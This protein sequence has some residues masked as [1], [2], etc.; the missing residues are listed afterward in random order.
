MYLDNPLKE[1]NLLQAIARTN[2][3]SSSHKEF[4]LI[5]DYIGITKC[6]DEALETYRAEDVCNAMRSLDEEKAALDEAHKALLPMLNNIPRSAGSKVEV[7]KEFDAL[8]QSLKTEDVW[9][10]FKRLARAFTRAYEALSPDPSVLNYQEDMKWVVGFLAYGTLI[11]EKKDA[12]DLGSFSAKIREMLS[13]HLDVTGITTICKL[14]SI[15][16]AEF[17]FDFEVEGKSEDDLKTAAIRKA[18]EL[19]K[20]LREKVSTNAAQYSKFSERVIEV[21]KRFEEGQLSAVE[22]LEEYK[23]I[24]TEVLAEETAHTESGMSKK[25]YGIRAILV[26]AMPEEISEGSPLHKL[27][28]DIDALYLN[29]DTAPSGWHQRDGLRKELRGSVRRL[30]VKQKELFTEWKDLPALIDDFAV[31]HYMKG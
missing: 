22:A 12:I 18:T 27:T 15:T 29:D 1:H 11:F 19:I 30:L 14:R 8:V 28:L 13:E 24:T 7:K 25:A 16:D 31:Q 3:V 20:I 9:M 5:V 26:K 2:R 6:L 17:N 23:Q 4:G 21:L 10:S